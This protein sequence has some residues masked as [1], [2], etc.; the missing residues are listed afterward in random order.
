M[1]EKNKNINST[2]SPKSDLRKETPTIMTL[3]VILLVPV[4]EQEVKFRF[5]GFSNF[6]IFI[7]STQCALT[8]LAS[9]LGPLVADVTKIRLLP[10]SLWLSVGPFQFKS[11]KIEL[12]RFWTNRLFA[13]FPQIIHQSPLSARRNKCISTAHC[14]LICKCVGFDLF[15]RNFMD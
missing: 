15:K 5:G 2:F 7:W 14:L 11:S 13:P 3:K 10:Y 9:P 12:I 4:F 6:V 1:S 8:W